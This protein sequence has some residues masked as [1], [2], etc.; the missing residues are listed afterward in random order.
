MVH[1]RD[2]LRRERFVDAPGKGKQTADKKGRNSMQKVAVIGA[3]GMGRTHARAYKDMENAALVGVLDIRKEAAENLAASVE[4][5]AFTDFEEMLRVTE[6]DVIDVCTPTPWHKEYVIKAAEARK[7]VI[8][9]KP[10]ARTL[11]DCYE[12][13]ETTSQAGVTF[14]VAHVLRFFPEFAAGKKLVESGA[15][16]RPAVVRTT[17]GGGYPHGWNDWF[18]NFEWSGGV[19][20]DLIIH[21]YDWMR[22][23]FGNVERVYAKGLVHRGIAHTDYALVTLRFKNGAI[24]HI[25]GT[26][27]NPVRFAV[28]Y[29][30][31]GDKGLIHFSNK[32]AV[33]L[34]IAQ[35]KAEEEKPG[36]PIPE[37]PT[38]QS[39]YYLELEHFIECIEKGKPPSI[40]PEDGLRVVEIGLAAIESMRTGLPIELPM[41]PR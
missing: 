3:G 34:I 36:V 22:W 35:A 25:E 30:V 26:W 29:E 13:I 18:G 11:A 31:A 8:T 9:E 2:R 14:M 10:M 12:M 40:T 33:P 37:S 20:L 21:D 39:P 6:P 38:A 7:H 17:R 15:V 1:V 4:C 41:Q 23:T 19:A 27:L 16:G 24:G 5:K 32:Q 28:E